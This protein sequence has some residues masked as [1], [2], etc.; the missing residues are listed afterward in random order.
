M[1]SNTIRHTC[2]LASIGTVRLSPWLSPTS[3][4]RRCFTARSRLLQRIAS[5]S[6]YVFVAVGFGIIAAVALMA[7]EGFPVPFEYQYRWLDGLLFCDSGGNRTRAPGPYVP[8]A[9][10]T[11]RFPCRPNRPPPFSYI[12]SWRSP[13]VQLAR[14]DRHVE[15]PS[16]ERQLRHCL[17]P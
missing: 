15:P 5:R 10:F 13:V 9:P 3:A 6:A 2:P 8:A 1:P 7:L 17:P 14:P 16:P 4:S 12:P 11:G